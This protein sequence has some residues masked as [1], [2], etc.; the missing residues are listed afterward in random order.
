MNEPRPTFAQAART[1][2]RTTLLDAASHLLIEYGWSDISMATIAA[3]A[4]VSRQT[5]YNEFGSREEFAQAFALREADMFLTAVED[6]IAAHPDD[7]HVALRSAF[8]CFLRRAQENPLVRAVLVR[9]PGSDD[10][11]AMFT[12]RGG[13]VLALAT[14]RLTRAIKSHWTASDEVDVRVVAEVLVR[15]AISHATLPTGSTEDAVESIS[16]LI[17]P[18]VTKVVRGPV[19]PIAKGVRRASGRARGR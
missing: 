9:G 11:L 5:L 4:G 12:T 1:L 16:V 7:P 17:G 18:F 8:E 14:E 13:P 3:R 6:S 2:L 19:V 15:L 10:L